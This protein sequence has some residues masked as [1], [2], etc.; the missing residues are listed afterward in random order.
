MASTSERCC[1]ILL[2]YLPHYRK[3]FVELLADNLRV[4]KYSIHLIYGENKTGKE[5]RCAEVRGCQT[6]LLESGQLRVFGANVGYQKGVVNTVKE[7]GP[8]LSQ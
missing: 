4:R 7:A 8:V 1:A 6:T 5:I 2:P 3:E